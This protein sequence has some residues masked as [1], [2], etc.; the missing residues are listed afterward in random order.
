[1]NVEVLSGHCTC[2]AVRYEMIGK[3]LLTLFAR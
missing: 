3:P 1:M 2:G